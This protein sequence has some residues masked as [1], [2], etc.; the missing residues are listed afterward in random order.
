M[1]HANKRQ[2]TGRQEPLGAIN[3]V[4][5]RSPNDNEQREQQPGAG[6]SWPHESCRPQVSECLP[7]PKLGT[8]SQVDMPSQR[9]ATVSAGPQT[10]EDNAPGILL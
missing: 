9:L 6:A 8:L 2:R 7:V 4:E 1:D 3:A 5:A 10:A